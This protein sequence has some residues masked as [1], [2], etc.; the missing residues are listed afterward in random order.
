MNASELANFARSRV[1]GVDGFEIISHGEIGEPSNGALLLLLADSAEAPRNHSRIRTVLDMLI[2]VGLIG[3]FMAAG[4]VVAGVLGPQPS[5]VLIPIALFA[6]AIGFWTISI[7]L[8]ATSIIDWADRR[9][10]AN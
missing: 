4:A 7:H 8:F 1:G 2:A 3:F 9:Q 5:Q 10:T 6:I